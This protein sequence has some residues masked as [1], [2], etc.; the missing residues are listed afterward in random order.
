MM[1][2]Q[3]NATFAAVTPSQSVTLGNSAVI[4]DHPSV[5]EHIFNED[6][7]VCI[8]NRPPDPILANYLRNSV[9]SGSW[10]CRARVDGISPDFEELLTGFPADVGRVRWVT[11]LTAL[12]ELFTTLTDART[13]GLRITAT[14][15][16]TCPRF[17][18]DQVSLRMLCCWVG[19]GT[20]FLAEEDIIRDA[21]GLRQESVGFAAGP[22]RSGGLVRR[23]RSFAVGAFKGDL[24]PAN[25]GHGAVHRSPQPEGWRVFVSL[26]ELC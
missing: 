6:V 22:I 25:E 8:W 21:V 3:T 5:F 13:V 2:N 19:E 11:E 16:A 1:S 17:H 24:W 18:C 14:D 23:M 7:T 20:E 4:E 12:V 9:G 10:E 15:R 26:D